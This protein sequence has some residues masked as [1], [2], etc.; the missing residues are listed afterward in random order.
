MPQMIKANP[1]K[2]VPSIKKE[3]VLVDFSMD[4]T[5]KPLYA[6]KFNRENH[7]II[8]IIIEKIKTKYPGLLI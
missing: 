2:I 1:V 7:K 8:P 4:K 6:K 3:S 5:L